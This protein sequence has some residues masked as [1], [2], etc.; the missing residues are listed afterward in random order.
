MMEYAF[1]ALTADVISTYAFGKSYGCVRPGFAPEWYNMIQC[2]SEL[3]HSIKQWPWL[4]PLLQS[5]PLWFVRLTNPPVHQ[6]LQLQKVTVL[7]ACQV[8]LEWI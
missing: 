2:P 8:I 3:S 1:S 5:F 6:L 4:F 7:P